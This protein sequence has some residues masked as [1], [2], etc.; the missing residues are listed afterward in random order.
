MCFV[1]ERMIFG[2]FLYKS[3]SMIPTDSYVA[4]EVATC[5]PS[6]RGKLS[7]ILILI[8]IVSYSFILLGLFSTS[9]Q[10]CSLIHAI[11][12]L[13]VMMVTVNLIQLQ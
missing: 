5:I 3:M 1:C 12:F 13:Y 10:K 2:L 6:E 7:S 8:M 11:Y 4:E 9:S